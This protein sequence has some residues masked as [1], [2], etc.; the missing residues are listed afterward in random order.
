MDDLI[1]EIAASK[2]KWP[3]RTEF[4]HTP[5]KFDD[6]IY[7]VDVCAKYLKEDY[8]KTIKEILNAKQISLFAVFTY[9]NK[10]I[11]RKYSILLRLIPNALLY[12]S[13]DDIESK[14]FTIEDFFPYEQRSLF[15]PTEKVNNE[16]ND[17]IASDLRF[18]SDRYEWNCSLSQNMPTVTLQ[19]LIVD[20]QSLSILKDAL[21]T[22]SL[23]RGSHHKKKRELVQEACKLIYRNYRSSYAEFF[24]RVN[25]ILNDERF[26]IPSGWEGLKGVINEECEYFWKQ[27]NKN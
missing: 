21:E 26:K 5:Y 27:K 17:L 24:E 1:Q 16:L 8:W 18:R 12:F 10:K 25:K 4:A 11:N 3:D 20:S 6:L 15:Q 22:I 9:K 14:I 19:K 13:F 7:F 2:N 23:K